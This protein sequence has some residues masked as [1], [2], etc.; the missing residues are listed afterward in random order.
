LGLR[1]FSPRY[2]LNIFAGIG[3]NDY[4]KTQPVFDKTREDTI[5]SAFAIFTLADLLGKE[6]LF[7]SLIARYSRRDS[8]IGFLDADTFLGGLPIG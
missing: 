7:S 4:D 8:N 6:R 1:K 3:R 2:V 5:Y